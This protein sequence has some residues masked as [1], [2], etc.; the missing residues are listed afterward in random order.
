MDQ[1]SEAAW[2][3]QPAVTCPRL[4]AGTSHSR[5]LE[6]GLPF[7]PP[8]GSSS[9]ASSRSSSSQSG[10]RSTGHHRHLGIRLVL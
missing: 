4:A 3:G 7:T 10:L 8:R 5:A 6:I 9:A 1:A 2:R